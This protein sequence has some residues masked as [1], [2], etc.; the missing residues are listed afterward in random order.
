[1]Q[2]KAGVWTQPNLS[3][4]EDDNTLIMTIQKDGSVSG[5]LNDFKIEGWIYQNKY[6]AVQFDTN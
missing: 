2:V 6:I 4:D 1:M 3:D 5:K